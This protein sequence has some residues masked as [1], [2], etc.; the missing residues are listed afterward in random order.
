LA[1][2]QVRLLEGYF[3]NF[4]E[5]YRDLVNAVEELRELNV[6]VPDAAEK[7]SVALSH[8][9]LLARGALADLLEIQEH[10]HQL[11]VR[12]SR[13]THSSYINILPKDIS[14]VE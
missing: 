13:R 9:R 2:D 6:G 10:I 8:V 7:L 3:D 12:R 5:K 1:A 11:S 4:Y 14:S